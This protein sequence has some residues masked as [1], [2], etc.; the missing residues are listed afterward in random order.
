[1][2]RLAGCARS[3]R[4]DERGL[5]AVRLRKRALA[6]DDDVAVENNIMRADG[7]E[8]FLLEVVVFG[9]VALIEQQCGG[10]GHGV[11]IEER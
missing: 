3:R 4:K 5:E 7:H 2:T 6:F 10:G 8:G 1:M 9:P 11:G